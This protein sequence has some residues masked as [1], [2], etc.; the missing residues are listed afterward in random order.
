MFRF[1][2]FI[3]FLLGAIFPSVA[4]DNCQLKNPLCFYNTDIFSYLQVLHKNQQYDQLSP[5]FYGPFCKQRKKADLIDKLSD[6]NFGYALKRVGI[7]EI[8][9]NKWS[10]TYQ[11][12]IFGTNENF[13]IE[14]ALINDTC[15][16]FID[17]TQWN[18]IFMKR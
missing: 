6:V 13:K 17:Q 7:K 2:L 3:V 18:R 1:I 9:K 10:V 8:E 4:Q 15:R 5:F 16:V 14:C 12:T 11:R